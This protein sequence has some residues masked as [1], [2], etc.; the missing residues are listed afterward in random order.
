MENKTESV[1][2]ES[3][4][5]KKTLKLKEYML[6]DFDRSLNALSK[7]RLP[8]KTSY[9]LA[10]KVKA[11]K[12]EQKLF[13]E[14]RDEKIKFFSVKDEKGECVANEAGQITVD[15]ERT[16]EFSESINKLLDTEIDAPEPIKIADLG[17][18]H[19]LT[20]EDFLNLEMLIS[21]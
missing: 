18:K 2:T 21:E 7:A 11:I 20:I 19:G 5:E 3:E 16:K 4:N 12:K 10:K 13:H 14:I 17:D 1:K 6:P 15:P 9:W 8:E